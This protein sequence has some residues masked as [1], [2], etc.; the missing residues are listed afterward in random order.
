MLIRTKEYGTWEMQ[1]SPYWGRY[2]TRSTDPEG[3]HATMDDLRSFELSADYPRLPQH[4]LDHIIS[5]MKQFVIEVQVV[6]ARHEEHRHVWRA[7]VPKQT[8]TPASV[9]ADVTHLVDLMTGETFT[10]GLPDGWLMAG[11]THLHPNMS[12][13]WSSVDDDSELLSPGLHFTIG[14]RDWGNDSYTICASICIGGN[15]HVFQPNEL[16]EVNCIKTS[17]LTSNEWFVPSYN[18]Y[19]LCDEVYDQ[20]TV[21]QPKPKPKPQPNSVSNTYWGVTDEWV[22]L[23][24]PQSTY[25]TVANNKHLLTEL[26]DVDCVIQDY[27]T[28]GGDVDELLKL[29]TKYMVGEYAI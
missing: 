7:F 3:H 9:K 1:T 15:R 4:L 18:K 21:Y 28:E 11:S 5:L 10:D 24:Y 2:F 27:L 17:K 25:K 12:A 14:G 23:L 22:D 19:L 6:L 8:N 26:A 13:F 20:I 16:I 29:L